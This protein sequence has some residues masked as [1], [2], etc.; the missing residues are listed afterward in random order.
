MA[1]KITGSRRCP[2]KGCCLAALAALTLV[3][4]RAP[5]QG[6][7][8]I[9]AGS[10][11]KTQSD[12]GDFVYHVYAGGVEFESGSLR[13]RADR[14]VLSVDRDVERQLV[15]VLV[16]SQAVPKRG[17]E[18]PITQS[19][20]LARS[21]A[22]RIE[23]RVGTTSVDVPPERQRFAPLTRGL[24]AEGNVVFDTDGVR[25]LRCSRLWLS[26]ASDRATMEDVV[27]RL[28]ARLGLGGKGLSLVLRAPRVVQQGPTIV[29][30]HASLS[31]CDAGEA[32]FDMRSERLVITRREADVYEVLGQGNELAVGILP[33]LPLPDYRWYSD[34][35]NWIPLKGLT[36]GSSEERGEFVFARFG[37]RWNDIGQGLVDFLGGADQPFRGEWNLRI[38]HTRK[39]GMPVEPRIT[40]RVPELFDG[41]TEGFYLSDRGEFDRRSVPSNIDSTPITNR[42]RSFVRSRNRIWL[43]AGRRLD[44][45]GFWGSDPAAFAEFAP[46]QLKELEI[47]E[48]S[49]EYRIREDNR[50][51]TVAA[52]MNLTDFAYD[53]TARLTDRFGSE[54]PYLRANLFSQPLFDVAEDVPLVVDA[55]VG[56][57]LLRNQFT[58]RSA[59]ARRERAYRADVDVEFSTPMRVGDFALRPWVGARET[60]YS[61]REGSTDASSR[62]ALSFGVSVDTRL[63]RY[64]DFSSEA[65]GI[66]GVWH[67]VRPYVNAYHR[68]DVD[69]EP[70]DWFQF[71]RVD[72]LDERAVV[73][74]GLLQRGLT[75]RKDG[76]G[77]SWFDEVLWLDLWQRVHPI[78]GR[79]NGGHRLGLFAWEFIFRPGKGWFPLPNTRILFE[80]E[81]DWDLGQDLTRNIGLATTF[82]NGVIA[83]AEW[84]TGLNDKGTGAAT[85]TVPMW[86]RWLVVSAL[87]YN[88]DQSR[89][90]ST[91]FQIV[92]RDHDYDWIFTYSRSELTDD[93]SFTMRFRPTFG[94]LIRPPS[95][96]YPAGAPAF[97]VTETPAPQEGDIDVV[98]DEDRYR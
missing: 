17:S 51:V 1:A 37:G 23:E 44:V 2:P 43:G 56:A 71:D 13:V 47:P 85:L 32:H 58:D 18:A 54:R 91:N 15:E 65:L 30:R 79:D 45:E 66:Y 22:R 5:A 27:L 3:S 98:R 57:G 14:M 46:N 63:A 39:R 55:H 49:I 64:F 4:A 29:A 35:E 72:A 36:V 48:S 52:R 78:S 25:A 77:R 87:V 69:R 28:P 61:E 86:D 89:T 60:L 24:L 16:D 9:Q 31:T 95:Y 62:T 50:L 7:Y 70:G 19:E 53:D 76:E 40:Y 82:D 12:D 96:R 94:G 11:S 34:Q 59:L 80:G 81:R 10:S 33:A 8:R 73:E 83:A 93:S 97:G 42:K 41:W 6:A 68:F 84:R 21:L 75:R 88:F 92:R 67:D 90:D 38:G 20:V 74:L 26:L